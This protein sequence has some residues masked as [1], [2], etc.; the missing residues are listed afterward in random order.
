LYHSPLIGIGVVKMRKGLTCRYILETTNMSRLKKIF[1]DYAVTLL[2]QVRDEDFE[3][4]QLRE[5]L[6]LAIQ[7]T[8]AP[9]GERED[10]GWSYG[11]IAL[12]VAV[13]VGGYVYYTRR[14]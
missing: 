2:S 8:S 14:R 10:N 9:H 5:K 4:E 7:V 3:A 12:G 6:R 11:W 1:H 13:G